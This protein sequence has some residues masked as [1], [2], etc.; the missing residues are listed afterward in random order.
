MENY[1][2]NSQKKAKD[3]NSA[4]PRIESVV[5][6]E[7]I[8]QKKS[9]GRRFADT[10]T[11]ADAKSVWE[12]IVMDVL[13]PAA[14]DMVSDAVSQGV[15]RML[16]GDSTSRS[17]GRGYSGPSSTGSYVSY[18]RFSAPSISRREGPEKKHRA[19]QSS[20]Q[21]EVILQSRHEADEVLDKLFDQVNNYDY[22]TVAD[23]YDLLGEES[24]FTDQNW[25]WT[26]MK[27]SDVVRVRQGYLIKLP[28][29]EPLN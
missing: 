21:N 7:V 26:S 17:R 3:E 28:K 16:F 24:Q 19:R 25:G 4:K 14:K 22:A 1:P 12:F 11:G 20:D 15:E 5:T 2:G 8:R 23:L 6:G 18:N 10:F 9:L 27:G 29:P 13:V